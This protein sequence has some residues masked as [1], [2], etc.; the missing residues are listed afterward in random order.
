MKLDNVYEYTGQHAI[1][2]NDGSVTK[3]TWTDWGLIPTSRHSEPIHPVWSNAVSVDGI[4]GEEDLVRHLPYNAVN[5]SDKLQS[6][7][8]N[9]NPEHILSADKYDILQPSSGSLSFYIADQTVSYFKKVQELANYFHG[10][11][12]TMIFTD[13]PTIQYLI[14]ATVESVESG[15]NFSG[16]SISYSVLNET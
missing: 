5:N 12:L 16:I 2:F 4:N 10:R 8:L 13:D 9:D 3:N 15:K 6:A 14:R 11:K 7:L 1:I